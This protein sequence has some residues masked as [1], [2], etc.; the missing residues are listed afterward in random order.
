MHAAEDVTR[1]VHD[2]P[3][4]PYADKIDDRSRRL[5]RNCG[6]STRDE[7]QRGDSL[8]IGL[9]VAHVPILGPTPCSTWKAGL[10]KG[11]AHNHSG[12]EGVLAELVK[13]VPAVA[14]LDVELA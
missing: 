10:G 13:M 3:G 12:N 6:Q 11:S 2:K 14:N 9:E 7:L 5:D 4:D 1:L 8:V